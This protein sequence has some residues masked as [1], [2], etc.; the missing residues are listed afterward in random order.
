MIPP[1]RDADPRSLLRIGRVGRAHGTQGAF[2]VVEPTERFE[3]LEAGSQL[4]VDGHGAA[5][6][7]ER[8]G[9]AARPII[10]LEEISDS[11]PLRGRGLLVP[12]ARIEL[13]SGE[14]LADDLVGCE[15][16]GVGTVTGV[17]NGPSADGLEVDGGRIVVPLVRDAVREIDLPSGRIVVELRFLGLEG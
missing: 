2:H 11:R 8:K 5:R 12:R 9:T 1:R 15:V 10:S 16:V 13:D 14:W 6:V 3:L 17:W 4:E 7:A